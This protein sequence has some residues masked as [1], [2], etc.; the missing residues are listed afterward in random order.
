[1]SEIL[2]FFYLDMNLRSNI[3]YMKSVCVFC[4]SSAG[5]GP[6]YIVAGRKLG[7]T[8]AS[9]DITVIYGGAAVG[10]MGAVANGALESGGKVIG[11]IPGFLSKKRN[12]A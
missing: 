11:V 4:G 5:S 3:R 7:E 10:I 6:E 8:L 1:M 12:Q 9:L 2:K